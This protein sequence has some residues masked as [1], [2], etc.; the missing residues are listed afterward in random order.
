MPYQPTQATTVVLVGFM[1]VYLAVLVRHAGRDRIDLYDLILLST[2]G[3]V[4]ASFVLFPGPTSR[5]AAWAGVSFP[6]LIL[7]GFL[8]LVAF[9][10]L[11]R[12]TVKIKALELKQARLV[13]DLAL[14]L[15]SVRPEPPPAD[16]PGG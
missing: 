12:L 1:V 4:P 16:P 8:L 13:Q 6:F 3:L 15:A 14:A 7:F 2:V 10:Y 9:V 11:Y 5:L